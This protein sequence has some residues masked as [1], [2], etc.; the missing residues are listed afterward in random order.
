[1][2]GICKSKKLF[3]HTTSLSVKYALQSIEYV[4]FFKILIG[5]GACT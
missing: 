2:H 1:M 4:P 3:M 5:H